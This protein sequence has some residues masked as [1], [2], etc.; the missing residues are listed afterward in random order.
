MISIR[1]VYLTGMPR[2]LFRNARLAGSW[3]GWVE[4]AMAEIVSED[5]CQAF[6]STVLFIDA[7]VGNTMRWGVRA[8]MPHS[9]NVWAMNFELNDPESQERYRVFQLPAAGSAAEERYYFVNNRR[10]GAQKV[11]SR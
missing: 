9:P 2:P 4:S 8:D 1:F 10:L 6:A 3:N 11:Y 7:Q 5:G